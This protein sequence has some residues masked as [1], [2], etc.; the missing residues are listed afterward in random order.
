MTLPT[1]MV[2]TDDAALANRLQRYLS[3]DGYQV[4]VQHPQSGIVPHIQKA[5]PD[6]LILSLP[7]NPRTQA[8][9]VLK[10][11]SAV[12]DA[13]PVIAVVDPNHDLGNQRHWF[14]THQ[15]PVLPTVFD[16]DTLRRVV[17]SARYPASRVDEVVRVKP[18]WL[19]FRQRADGARDAA[20]ASDVERLGQWLDD[21]GIAADPMSRI[22]ALMELR[23]R[24][25]LGDAGAAT[26]RDAVIEAIDLALERLW[27]ARR[28]QLT[29]SDPNLADL[30]IW[31]AVDDAN[32]LAAADMSE[33]TTTA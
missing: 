32:A 25:L 11:W 24:V 13:C 31:Q 8:W 17:R 29:R 21:Q 7:E 19:H 28:K 30:P 10:R 15:V 14:T 18:S 12:D 33:E 22:N 2:V 16:L 27:L 1:V 23:R 9:R 5:K 6:L 3:N 4:V 20:R 26:E